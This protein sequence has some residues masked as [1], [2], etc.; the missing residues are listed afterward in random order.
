MRSRLRSWIRPPTGGPCPRPTTAC[1]R[2]SKR[3]RRPSCSSARRTTASP[4]VPSCRY[5][6]S[7]E[8][9]IEARLEP[10]HSRG[11]APPR[12]RARRLR[13]APRSE[14]RRP[15]RTRGAASTGRARDRPGFHRQQALALQLLAGELAGAADGFR[16]FADSALGRLFVVAAQ[17]HLA[18]HALALHLLLQHLERLVDIVVTDENL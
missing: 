17:L 13:R 11:S 4:A 12:P 15:W 6:G 2:R 5:T 10:A 1:G 8:A 14:A 18:E 3:S 9:C 7:R 16:L